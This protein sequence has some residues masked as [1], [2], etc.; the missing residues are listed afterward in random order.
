MHDTQWSR[1]EAA[2]DARLDPFADPEL[3]AALAADPQALRRVH[4]LTERLDW[5]SESP[6]GRSRSSSLHLSAGV[7]AAFVLCMA[8]LRWEAPVPALRSANAP[9]PSFSS[10]TLTVE[11][12]SPRPARTARVVLEP[13]RV[14]S[15][16]HSG[17][18]Q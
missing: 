4:M 3:A 15:W 12:E 10:I 18:S 5:L 14:V 7:A 6:A 2:L 8:A 16:N 1:V 9:N 17:D 11:H 13:R